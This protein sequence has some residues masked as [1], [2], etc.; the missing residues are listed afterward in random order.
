MRRSTK[1]AMHLIGFQPKDGPVKPRQMP[2]VQVENQTFSH[3]V[4]LFS[5]SW[6]CFFHPQVKNPNRRCEEC[7]KDRRTKDNK[8]DT[9]CDLCLRLTCSLHYVRSCESCYLTKFMNPDTHEGSGEEEEVD[10]EIPMLNQDHL[11]V[12][13]DHESIQSSIFNFFSHLSI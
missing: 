3:S 8:T 10:E 7:K 12:L 2:R 5:L 6:L 9:V 4:S 13:S 11:R 1:I